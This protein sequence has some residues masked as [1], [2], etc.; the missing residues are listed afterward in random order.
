M[1]WQNVALSWFLR[2][3]MKG[4]GQGEIDVA[5]A[6]ALAD[7]MWAPRRAPRDWRIRAV[8][9]RAASEGQVGTVAAEWIEPAAAELTPTLS[10]TVLYLHGGA[11]LFCSPRTHRPITCAL[12]RHGLARVLAPEYRLAP[13]HPAPAA[14]DDAL[15]AYRGLLADGIAPTTIVVAGDSAGGGLTLA[16]LLALRDAGDP[17]PAAGVLFSPWTDLA[18]TGAT[19]DSHADSDVLFDG[20][21]VRAAARLYLAGMPGTDWRASP[22]YGDFT[23]L[24]PLLI[25][26]SDSEVLLDDARRVVDKARAAGVEVAF[27][28][29]RGVPHAWQIFAGFLPE[30]RVALHQA[31]D[32]IRRHART[33]V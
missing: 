3:R 22:L 14:L 30:A 29:W 2:R 27:H 25:Q 19:I 33:P 12:A 24:P 17:L 18:V 31:G 20:R 9:A 15:A 8:P 16:L 32:F 4:K 1:S 26:A 10:R 28:Q 21:G 5:E 13:E 23:G 6:R 11:Y 7:R